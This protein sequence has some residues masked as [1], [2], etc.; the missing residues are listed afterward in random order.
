MKVSI[1]IP[2]RWGSPMLTSPYEPLKYLKG[3]WKQGEGFIIYGRRLELA[4]GS[5]SFRPQDKMY[6]ETVNPIHKAF[7]IYDNLLTADTSE[8]TAEVLKVY[9][10]LKKTQLV[11]DFVWATEI[12]SLRLIADLA[13]DQNNH[14]PF[15]LMNP[16]VNI[17][18]INPHWSYLGPWMGVGVDYKGEIIDE[19]ERLIEGNTQDGRCT[20]EAVA[21]KSVRETLDRIKT[22][23]PYSRK[24]VEKR[25]DIFLNAEKL[26]VVE[27]RKVLI[28]KK[29]P[30]SFVPKRMNEDELEKFIGILRS[31]KYEVTV[32][33][34]SYTSQEE[35]VPGYRYY[36]ELGKLP[37]AKKWF[38]NL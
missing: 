27:G 15:V 30:F 38:E 32:L 16:A 3:V 4:E 6:R 12:G 2:N 10:E 31:K 19:A 5:E 11:V 33:E 26:P 28:L 13:A 29:P 1:D 7:N 34:P 9:G 8:F 35:P 24:E 14:S 18:V 23:E 21:L 22:Y 25:T 17:S 20:L 36:P 37:E